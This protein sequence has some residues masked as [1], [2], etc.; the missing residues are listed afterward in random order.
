[1]I[2]Q[3]DENQLVTLKFSKHA[4]ATKLRW[5]HSREFEF[6]EV[7]Y[8]IVKSEEKEDSV[9]YLCWQDVEE[10]VLNKRFLSILHSVLQKD[11][12]VNKLFS[13]LV[14]TLSNYFVFEFPFMEKNKRYNTIYYFSHIN[15]FYKSIN[16][17]PSPPPPN[18]KAFI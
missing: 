12:T 14:N 9:I 13:Q 6:N 11:K 4:L 2:S 15:N 16:I 10:T 1:L 8:D 17:S 18:Y 5:K 7:M 3:L